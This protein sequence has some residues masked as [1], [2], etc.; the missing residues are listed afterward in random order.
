[1]GSWYGLRGVRQSVGA[2]WLLAGALLIPACSEP[3]EI[4]DAV[5]RHADKSKLREKLYRAWVTRGSDQSN[6]PE[7]DNSELIE[8]ILSLRH[9]A[10]ELVGFDSYA[11]YS[12][13]TKMA[14][15]SDEVI[16]F[17]RELATRSRPSG[18]RGAAAGG[19]GFG[20]WGR[21]KMSG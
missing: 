18:A 15:S 12:L 3:A 4:P 21:G 1:M 8:I 13:A 6:H 14:N 7:W 19:P 10:A 5:M 11:D 2:L 20:P 16:N 9:E 17:L